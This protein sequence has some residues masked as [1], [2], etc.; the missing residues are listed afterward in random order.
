M[1]LLMNHCSSTGMKIRSM[2]PINLL[3][4]LLSPFFLAP[5]PPC[6]KKGAQSKSRQTKMVTSFHGDTRRNVDD[7]W[8][9]GVDF[10]MIPHADCPLD[11]DMFSNVHRDDEFYYDSAY[12]RVCTVDRKMT[13]D[14]PFYQNHWL[15]DLGAFNHMYYTLLGRLLFSSSGR[16]NSQYH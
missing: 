6:S 9:G 4:G 7:I 1:K 3:L 12:L 2:K 15:I 8:K 10:S 5:F 14:L 16:K 11:D 13:K